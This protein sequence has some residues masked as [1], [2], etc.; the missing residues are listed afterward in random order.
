MSGRL[1]PTQRDQILRLLKSRAPACVPL[2]D[3]LALRIGQY[4]ARIFELRRLGYLIESRREGNKSWFR[5]L[6]DRKPVA[7]DSSVLE[8]GV[9]NSDTFPQFG[10]LAPERRYPD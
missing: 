9:P 5:L 6:P 4:N 10:D 1:G 7:C 2:P 8:K 3:I